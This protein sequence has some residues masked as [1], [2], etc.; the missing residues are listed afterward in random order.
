MTLQISDFLISTGK[1]E[2]QTNLLQL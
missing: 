1:I 2:F